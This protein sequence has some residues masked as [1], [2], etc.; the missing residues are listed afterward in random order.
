MNTSSSNRYLLAQV[1]TVTFFFITKQAYFYETRPLR[2]WVSFKGSK[3]VHFY[4]FFFFIYS[5][6]YFIQTVYHIKDTYLISTL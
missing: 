3:R 2:G 4:Y 5:M 1:H 6:K